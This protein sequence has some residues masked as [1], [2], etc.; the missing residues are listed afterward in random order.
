MGIR[1][2][3][4]P[5]RV[6]A[7]GLAFMTAPAFAAEVTL[8]MKGGTFEVSGELKSFNLKTYVVVEP[9]LGALSLDAERY[10]CVAGTCP[11]G[12]KEATRLPALPF[13]KVTS[14]WVGGSVIGT[15]FMPRLIQA[16][17][18]S[19]GAKVTSE[20]G[21]DVKN[22]DFVLNSA[23]GRSI[24]QISVQ[25]QGVTPGFFA[26]A[27]GQADVVWGSRPIQPEEEQIMA[28]AGVT[29]LRQPGSEHVWGLDALV[30]LVAKEN[31]AVSLSI[32]TV[33]KIFS[34][35][36]KDWSEIGLPPG[37]INVYAPT[38]EMGTWG[39]FE[40]L[41]MVPRGRKIT[42]NATRLA[43][44]T[45]WSDK[46][47]ADPQGISISS[48]AYVRRAKPINIET[49]CGIVVPPSNFAAK[50]EEYPLTRRLYFYTSGTP[51]NPL[52][53]GLL[54]FALSEQVQPVLKDARFVDQAPELLAFREQRGRIATALNAR[55]EDYDAALM[56]QMIEETV[57]AQR[58]S[59]TFRFLRGSSGLDNRGNDDIAR[60]ALLLQKDPAYVGK[61]LML[62]GFADA[63][64]RFDTN[65]AIARRRTGLVKAALLRAAPDLART[66]N[67]VERSF[68]ELAPVA[69]NETEEGRTLNRRVEVWIR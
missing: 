9:T 52:T 48:L 17:A 10:E 66:V 43:H 29:N 51:K 41:V 62:L 55:G 15:E 25:R 53:A 49:E 11:K 20:V 50:T 67:I 60:L 31:P 68:G 37:K 30:F 35:E 23:D 64:G 58:S 3:T 46:V 21:S 18:T 59:L 4:H 6:L 65:L 13:E 34:G 8:R 7:A 27:K 39:S 24:G 42:N 32:D 69:C 40:S 63:V 38:T 33:S 57:Q 22:L 19:L 54:E 2:W 56:R 16:Y 1:M 45:E 47:A 28:S 44:A 12:A 26:M 14:T 5:V 36:I 61:T